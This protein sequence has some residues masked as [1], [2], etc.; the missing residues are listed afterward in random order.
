MAKQKNK[1]SSKQPQK[2]DRLDWQQF[3]FLENLLIF[4]VMKER[5]VPKESGV[6]FRITFNERDS[7]VCLLFKTD[8]K[9][10]PLVRES[11]A[12]PDYLAFFA[13]DN[14][15]LCTLIEM[16]GKNDL[17]R[18]VEQVVSLKNILR[19]EFQDHLPNRLRAKIQFQAIL[20]CPFNSQV[21]NRQILKEASAGLRILP[22]LWNQKAELSGYVSKI[23]VLSERYEHKELRNDRG[24]N[25][26]ESILVTRSLAK[27][28]P[29]SF[30]AEHFVQ[31]SPQVRKGLYVNYSLSDDG[32]YAALFLSNA[33]SAIGIS[34]NQKTLQEALSQMLAPF[35]VTG[36]Q[37]IR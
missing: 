27:R 20:V 14:L 22:I 28:I 35:G 34:E 9:A 23:N 24:L 32:D 13:R 17:V 25:S 5:N 4:C 19:R 6:H 7:S 15:C 21:P 31:G 18:G 16:K 3:N 8:R 11:V 33:T 26:L 37:P 12:R 10:D 36:L 2:Q 30:Y 1:L 29:D